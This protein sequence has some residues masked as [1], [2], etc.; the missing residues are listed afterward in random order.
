M[1]FC[2]LA[3]G[4]F[5][6][7]LLIG[8]ASTCAPV[9]AQLLV[10]SG[11]ENIT[12]AL[13]GN[14]TAVN[15]GNQLFFSNVLANAPGSNRVLVQGTDISG[16]DAPVAS[17]NTFYNTLPGVTSTIQAG[18]V[19]AASLSGVNLFVSAIPATA[20][21]PAEI[22]ALSNFST[23]GGSIFLLGDGA[24]FA[25]VPDANL[26]ALLVGLGS[27]LLIVPDNLDPGFQTVGGSQIAAGNPLT[28]G[29]TSFTYTFVSQVSGGTSLFTASGGQT[30]IAATGI[31]PTAVPEP[32]S[33]ALLTGLSL[34]G[35]AF[36]RRRKH[37]HEAA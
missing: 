32:G 23:G 2:K 22:T 12:N 27:S 29:V 30:Y 8:F 9:Q 16:F 26:N 31:R 37:A 11:D 17:I 10:V 20:F 33:I 36:L 19:T 34:T 15:V 28:A 4:M 18:P 25:P 14:G 7:A 3:L 13:V 24:N 1:R 6:P 21:T 5:S 35:A